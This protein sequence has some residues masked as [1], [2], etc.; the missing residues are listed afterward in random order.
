MRGPLP[1]P[2]EL[3]QAL[4]QAAKPPTGEI[5]GLLA[6]IVALA[7]GAA[8]IAACLR[9]W[10]KGRED[11]AGGGIGL[12]FTLNDLREMRD[13]GQLDEEEF[14]VA[15]ERLLQR[16]G[17]AAGS[18]DAADAAGAARARRPPPEDPD[19]GMIVWDD[20]ADPPETG[21]ER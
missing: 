1:L 19:D 4:A 10:L 12:G 18:G 8:I 17:A 11:D 13:E 7:V 15:R 14:A 2:V 20:P 9:F 6:W 3:L 16:T 5:F 21:D